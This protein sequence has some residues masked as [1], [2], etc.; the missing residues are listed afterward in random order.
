MVDVDRNLRRLPLLR[1][2]S[3]SLAARG[4]DGVRRWGALGGEERGWEKNGI[5]GKGLVGPE[6]LYPGGGLGASWFRPSRIGQ[7]G[8]VF[9]TA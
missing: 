4:L 6:G 8:G 1:R 2:R 7:R 5:Q 9:W 3:S